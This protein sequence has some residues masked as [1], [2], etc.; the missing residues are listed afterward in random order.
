M[1]NCQPGGRSCFGTNPLDVCE[2]A[3]THGIPDDSC[4]QYIAHNS[5]KPLCSPLQIC[6]DCSSP[7]PKEGEDGKVR[8]HPVTNYKNFFVKEYGR[9][10]G[11][12]RIESEIFKRGP[13]DCGIEVTEKFHSYNGG[14]FEEH[15]G[16]WNI[17]HALL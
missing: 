1:V 14:I 9:V 16:W 4:Q 13:I 15:K 3:Y 10:S 11:A 6:Q 5:A 2:F 7:A 8:W 17:N 12:S